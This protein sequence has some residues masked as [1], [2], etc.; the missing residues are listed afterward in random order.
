MPRLTL[1]RPAATMEMRPHREVWILENLRTLANWR[2]S[3]S[4]GEIAVDTSREPDLADTVP[5][6]RAKLAELVVS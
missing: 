4:G 5:R 6:V 2:A 3:T 1:S